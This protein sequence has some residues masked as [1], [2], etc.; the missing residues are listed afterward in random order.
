MDNKKDDKYYFKKALKEIEI[1]AEYVQG[2]D[3]ESFI[4][5]RKTIDATVKRLEELVEHIKNMSIEFKN[6]HPAIP[7]GDITGFRNGLVHEYGKTDYTTV[8][9]VVSKDIYDLRN[10]FV[11][12]LK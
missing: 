2:L 12:S 10:L 7:W 8:Y 9:E 3:Y 1:I 5:D 6:E 11:S 4:N